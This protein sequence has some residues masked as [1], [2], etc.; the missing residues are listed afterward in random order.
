MTSDGVSLRKQAIKLSKDSS[1]TSSAAFIAS[2]IMKVLENQSAEESS[3]LEGEIA[4]ILSDADA[5]KKEFKNHIENI[6]NGKSDNSTISKLEQLNARLQQY[7]REGQKS[8]SNTETLLSGIGSTIDGEEPVLFDAVDFGD[9]TSATG[10]D[11]VDQSK[12]EY[13][14]W[15]ILDYASGKYA[16]KSGEHSAKM[17]D[18]G[19]SVQAQATSVNDANLSSASG[20]KSRVEDVTGVA[21]T[22]NKK[23]DENEGRNGEVKEETLEKTKTKES[24]KDIKASQNDGTDKTAKMDVSIDEILKRKV[25]KGEWLES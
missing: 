25:R 22:P 23:K 4:K 17:G 24:D 10:K 8:I 1:N 9:V 11:L 15:R 21:G 12:H 7:G 16:E 20:L 13:F 3:E 6:N 5:L 19:Y 2:F 14:I 18:R